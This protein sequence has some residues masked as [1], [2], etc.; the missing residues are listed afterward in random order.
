MGLLG[1]S[2][3]VI[4]L[5]TKEIGIRK[6]LGAT[7]GGLLVLISKDFVKLVMLASLIAVPI[8]YF[9]AKAW[10]DNYAFHIGLGASIFLVPPLLLLGL[11]LLTISLQ[12]M[13]AALS[14]PVK[15]LK[16]E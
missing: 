5:R 16:S 14:N 2:S 9:I 7:I 15:S 1:L 4:R 6:V 3:F 8:V 10:L 11:T 13:K 12:S